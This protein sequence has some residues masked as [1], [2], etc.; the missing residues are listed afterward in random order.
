MKPL[1]DRILIQ[2]EDPKEEAKGI[3]IPDQ[4]QR[5]EPVV[6]ATVQAVG[7]DVVELKKGDRIMVGKYAGTE[8][9][10]KDKSFI[11]MREDD[12]LAMVKK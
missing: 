12:V 2:R 11:I 7:K 10:I 6:I 5:N 3:V 4:Y 1:A 9:M 8:V